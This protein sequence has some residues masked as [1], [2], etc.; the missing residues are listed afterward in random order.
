MK[1]KFKTQAYQS[2]AVQA[3]R[4]MLQ[5][6][7]RH[8]AG[9]QSFA[10]ETTLAGTARFGFPHPRTGAQVEARIVPVDD[11]ALYSLSYVSPDLY[12]VDLTLEVL[13]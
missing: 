2:A 11:G 7:D 9:R 12:A 3:G 1:L 13:P 5:E 10:F 6:L 4:L 8:F